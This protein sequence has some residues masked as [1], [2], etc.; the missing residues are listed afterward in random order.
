MECEV[1][2]TPTKSVK[3]VV[4]KKITHKKNHFVQC[5]VWTCVMFLLTW[6]LY[7]FPR[8]W[9]LYHFFH[10]MHGPNQFML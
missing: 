3:R 10:F 5:D 6:T 1:Q 9:T 4:R 8:T 2:A 7:Q